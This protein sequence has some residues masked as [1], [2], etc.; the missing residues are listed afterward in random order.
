MDIAEISL[1]SQH[2]RATFPNTEP[3]AAKNMRTEKDTVSY[4]L[5]HSNGY[6]SFNQYSR[7]QNRDIEER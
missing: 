6:L 7:Q 3:T 1:E 2:E 5:T 4:G